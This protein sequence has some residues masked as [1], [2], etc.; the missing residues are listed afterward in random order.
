MGETREEIGRTIID[1]LQ[2][3]TVSCSDDAFA[4]IHTMSV[5]HGISYLEVLDRIILSPPQA[6]QTDPDELA[7]TKAE[8]QKAKDYIKQLEIRLMRRSRS[9]G[10][11]PKLNEEDWAQLAKL[12]QHDTGVFMREVRDRGLLPYD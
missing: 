5:E 6:S 3:K 11:G 8:L 9:T 12:G 4:V 1:V 10:G 2:M 7:R